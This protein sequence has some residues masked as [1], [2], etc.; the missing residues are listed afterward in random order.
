M[1]RIPLTTLATMLVSLSA[2]SVQAANNDSATVNLTT[3]VA[4]TCHISTNSFT[5]ISF[6]ASDINTDTA[7]LTDGTTATQAITDV[8]CNFSG[9]TVTV[10]SPAAGMT[11]SSAP[12]IITGDFAGDNATSGT[13]ILPYTAKAQWGSLSTT[14]DSDSGSNATVAVSGANRAD[15]SITVT[16]DNQKD[17]LLAGTYTDVVTVAIAPTGP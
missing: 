9:T 11:N 4:S 16:M 15:L 8:Y 10:S 1:K 2:I 13:S 6:G 17:P 7:L 12:T 5:A 3:T 14:Y